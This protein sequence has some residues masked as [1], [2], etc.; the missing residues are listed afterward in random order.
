MGIYVNPGNTAFKEAV[1]SLIY[2][3]KSELISYMNQCLNT[4]QK[5][6]CVSRPRYFGKS[7]AA[8]MLV[9]YYSRGCR[10]KALFSGRKAENLTV[11]YPHTPLSL[12]YLHKPDSESIRIYF[13]LHHTF[14][15]PIPTLR[16]ASG[17]RNQ[18]T[19]PIYDSS[20]FSGV[21]D[22]KAIRDSSA[23]SFL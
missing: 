9:A 7:M 8:D 14:L 19:L 21:P 22:C 3:D 20:Y 1:N 12:F 16:L 2:V 11:P 23:D 4:V 5:N 13:S 6:I 18:H 17:F 15:I 10:S